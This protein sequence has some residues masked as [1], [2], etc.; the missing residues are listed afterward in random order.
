[1]IPEL[2]YCA[3]NLSPYAD[4]AVNEYGFIRGAQLPSSTNGNVEFADQNFH[5][6]DREK[7]M[8]ALA[9]HK[10]RIATVQDLERP[11][12]LES[13]LCQA[14]EASCY[15]SEAVIIIPKYE[16]AI[17]QLPRFINGVPVRLGYS[18]KSSHGQTNVPIAEFSGWDIHE[19]GGEPLEQKQIYDKMQAVGARVLSCD[20][21][22]IQK[23]AQNNQ[24]LQIY[25]M[26]KRANY[27]YP[28][29]KDLGFGDVTQDATYLAF[30]ISC[31]NW[32]AIWQNCPASLRF[33]RVDDIDLID[34]LAR[35]YNQELSYIPK[36]SLCESMQKR[37][38]VCAWIGSKLVGF[39]RFHARKD[40]RQTVYEIAV[41]P[42]YHGYNIGKGLLACVPKPIQLK[43]TVDNERAIGFYLS[44]GFSE[45]S[46][47]QGRKRELLVLR[48]ER[49]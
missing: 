17:A 4:I 39:V 31:V 23:M 11:E 8:R 12:Q 14:Y 22:S 29:L 26:H 6:P 15:V 36:V 24:V 33:A 49:A 41:H 48:K 19:L 18:V 46:R 37:E 47:E 38:L 28:Q 30:R 43:V 44:Q 34:Q 35:K 1:M 21:N 45:I 20:G 27:T 32:L 5:K 40:G 25:P 16:G 10:P 3:G 7:Y 42:D 2:I 9:Q 13:V